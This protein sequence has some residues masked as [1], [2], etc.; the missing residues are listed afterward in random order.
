MEEGYKKIFV[1]WETDEEVVLMELE[2]SSGNPLL[3]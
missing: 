1:S 2:G 3:C